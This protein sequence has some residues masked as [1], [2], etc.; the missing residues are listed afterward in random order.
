VQLAAIQSGPSVPGNEF[1]C[2]SSPKGYRA[3]EL[4]SR[5]GLVPDLDQQ[6]DELLNFA[7]NGSVKESHTMLGMRS[8]REV[9][10]R[11]G[12]FDVLVWQRLSI[13]MVGYVLGVCV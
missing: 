4:Q 2:F 5:P 9:S 13:D 11:E 3:Q 8:G 1:H 7:K 12:R 6:T 10:D